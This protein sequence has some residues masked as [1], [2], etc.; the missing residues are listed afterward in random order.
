MRD[1]SESTMSILEARIEALE[2]ENAN[3]KNRLNI[4]P[5]KDM[6]P[7]SIMCKYEL[8]FQSVDAACGGWG[9]QNKF[10]S[11]FKQLMS[12]MIRCAVFGDT[13][14]RTSNGHNKVISVADMTEEDFEIYLYV[15]DHVLSAFEEG[16]KKRK[17][18]NA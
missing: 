4:N 14:K 6:W 7:E 2:R 1:D 12:R 3:L 15:L 13:A 9:Y 10:H 8:V 17:G 11:Q 16:L 5:R 18:V